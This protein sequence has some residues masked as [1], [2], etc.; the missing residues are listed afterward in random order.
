MIARVDSIFSIR[1]VI[2]ICRNPSAKQVL[3]QVKARFIK[4]PKNRLDTDRQMNVIT[5]SELERRKQSQFY[6]LRKD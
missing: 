3:F 4:L 6:Q 1:S 2:R 5:Q